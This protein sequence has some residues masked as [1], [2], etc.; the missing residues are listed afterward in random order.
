MH[1]H[2]DRQSAAQRRSRRSDPILSR[3]RCAISIGTRAIRLER[4]GTLSARDVLA[5]VDPIDEA[6]R[7]WRSRWGDDPVAAMAA[8]TSVMRVEQI[9]MARL[10]A[11]LRPFELNPRAT[12]R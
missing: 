1:E 6:A 12:R 10:N 4:C 8:V 9:L 11:L 3:M 7:Q 5:A 2:G